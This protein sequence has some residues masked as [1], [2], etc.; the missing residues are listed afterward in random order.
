MPA[1]FVGYAKG[2]RGDVFY[3]SRDNKVFVLTNTTFLE[4]NYIANFKPQSKIVMEE[5]QYDKISSQPMRVFIS[6]T[7]LPPRRS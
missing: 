5:L 4:N 6:Q 1:S 2:T 3:N 7:V